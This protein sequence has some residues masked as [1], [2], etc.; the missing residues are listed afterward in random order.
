[1]NRRVAVLG[2]GTMGM[3]IAGHMV[4]AGNTVFG[5]DVSGEIQARGHELGLTVCASPAEA[6]A[7]SDATFVIVGL[8]EQVLDV[9]LNDET[10]VIAGARPGHVV[11]IASTVAPDVTVEVARQL[12][13]KG[14]EV[15]D[16][17]LS[18]SHHAAIDGSLLVLT[19]GNA[20]I[21]EDWR[22]VMESFAS[23]IIHV[24]DVGA[25][26]LAKT[27]NNLLLW[28]AVSGNREAMQLGMRFGLDQARL[29]ATVLAGSG[30][31]WAL[32]TWERARP[33]P[34]AED[35]LTIALEIAKGLGLEMAMTEQAAETIAAIK[36]SKAALGLAG[37]SMY[38]YL[39]STDGPSSKDH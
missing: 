3:P 17:T 19:G 11:F 21:A 38:T 5:Y 1:M 7:S 22:N 6:A 16:A 2:L 31:S 37:E 10:G 12:L 32:E 14:V 20:A 28:I 39:E 29:R 8:G 24:G 23:D 30:G 25:G 18:R 36:K 13:P 26:Q 35:D 9:C 34:W 33:M 27:I 15:L 4:R